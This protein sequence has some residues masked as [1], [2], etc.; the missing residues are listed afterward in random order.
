M[1]HCRSCNR[2]FKREK[3]MHKHELLCKVKANNKSS[4]KGKKFIVNTKT[5]PNQVTQSISL[6]INENK[7]EN[8][9]DKNIS[10]ITSTATAAIPNTVSI[11]MDMDK[12]DLKDG[13]PSKR[14]MYE[15]LKIMVDKYSKL[16]HE[17]IEMKKYIEKTK[18]KINVIDWLNDNLH[19]HIGYQEWK[20]NVLKVT[21][22][23]LECVFKYKY[24]R[25]VCI[26]LKKYL[27]LESSKNH[28]IC[29][30][31]QK[32]NV[33]YKYDTIQSQ[34]TILSQNQVIGLI[35]N[36]NTKLT[37]EFY[38]WKEKHQDR[39]DNDDRFHEIYIDNMRAIL[40]DNKSLEEHSRTIKSH[41]FEYLKMDVKNMI[42]FE[43]SV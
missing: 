32:P 10:P 5:E 25:G 14:Q 37:H 17:M 33:F 6:E 39:I 12:Q 9:N 43:F 11:D 21:D 1:F 23:D 27:P 40:G 20:E 22:E 3:M 24:S 2:E 13:L 4:M 41:L 16:E 19:P 30:F 38:K 26:I 7:N 15:L 34:W 18:K 28:P 29:C 8:E 31:K 42:E 36:V 35:T